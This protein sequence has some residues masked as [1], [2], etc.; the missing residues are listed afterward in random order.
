MTRPDHSAPEPTPGQPDP[1]EPPTLRQ[2]LRH[3]IS[4]FFFTAGAH[5]Y[6]WMTWTAVWRQHCASLAEHF[7]RESSDG[8]RLS[9]LDLGIGPG[10]SGI[11]ILDVRPQSWVVGLDF[12]R[13]MLRLAQRYL[14]RARCTLDLVHGDVMHLPF[15]DAS[16]DVV[17]HHSF[18]Y[19]LSQPER[20]LSEIAR[21]LRPDGVYVF[22]EPSREGSLLALLLGPG[23]FRFK[24]SMFLWRVV[25][26]GFG[27]F[28]RASLHALLSRH[29]FDEIQLAPTL[30]DMGFLGRTRRQ[31]GPTPRA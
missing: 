31:S 25:S 13:T 24:L 9:V 29:G 18:L 27:R 19:L 5:F 12:S 4:L 26:R 28:D 10:I 20:A 15:A 7:P 30:C 23:V 21:V 1:L 3:V 6:A 22:L 14:R 8:K 2:R 16:F 11:G 17:T